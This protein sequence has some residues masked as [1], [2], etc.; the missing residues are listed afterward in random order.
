M[1]Y[2]GR[3]SLAVGLAAMLVAIIVG[4]HRSAPSPACRAAASTPA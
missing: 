3:I 2:G 1:L 4:T